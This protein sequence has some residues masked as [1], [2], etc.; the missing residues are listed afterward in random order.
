[1]QEITSSTE[2]KIKAAAAR[3]FQKKGYAAT[4]TR[5]IAEEAG[6]N[7]ALLHYYFRSKDN[8]FEM[9]VGSALKQF[10]KVM[11][12]IFNSD[13][14]LHQK[15]KRFVH[16]YVE[17]FKENPYIPLFLI[18]ESQINAERVNKMIATEAASD[19]L[20]DQLE[21]LADQGVIRRIH[22]AQFM[23]NLTSMTIFPFISKPIIMAKTDLTP[24]MYDVLLEERKVMIPE[25]IINYLYLKKPD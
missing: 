16:D 7:I 11:D 19:Q 10:S 18:S 6:I 25:I 17:F 24:E 13:M 8:L 14:P 20:K 22:Y 12:A 23:M 3:V 9:V 15:I 21:R 1:M 2:D 4:K 5:D